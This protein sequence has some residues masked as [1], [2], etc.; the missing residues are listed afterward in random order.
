MSFFSR[1]IYKVLF[2]GAMLAACLAAWAFLAGLVVLSHTDL[3]AR[4]N[5]WR[6]G[7]A[8]SGERDTLS[9]EAP[10]WA[11]AVALLRDLDATENSSAGGADVEAMETRQATATAITLPLAQVVRP[12][13]TLHP[14]RPPVGAT[15]GITI[16]IAP[17]PTPTATPSPT[18]SPTPTR[19]TFNLILLG[20]DRNIPG[21]GTWRTDVMALTVIDRETREVGVLAIPRDLYVSIPGHPPERLNTVDFLGHYTKYPGG[22]PALLDRTLRQN[23]GFGFDRYIRVDFTGFVELIDLLGGIDVEVDCPFEERFADPEVPGGRLL[24][25]DAGWQHL[26]GHTALMYV[27]SRLTTNDWDRSRRQFK[28]LMALREKLLKLDTLLLIPQLWDNYRVTVQTDLSLGEALDL[29]RLA[30]EFDVNDIHGQ[31]ID[32]SMTIP[33]RTAMKSWVLLPEHS[34]IKQAYDQLFSA[35]SLIEAGRHRGKCP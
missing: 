12:T 29:A 23:F 5:R 13:S 27:R 17:L 14:H 32:A 1:H 24:K 31:V 34:K 8:A 30:Y 3:P 9:A 15:P 28:V 11:T 21:K 4:V 19:T 2:L 25:L 10:T 22:G 16:V 26:D 33:A 18:P 20:S 7:L 6:E 35:P